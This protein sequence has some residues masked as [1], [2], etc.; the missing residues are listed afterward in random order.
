MRAKFTICCCSTRRRFAARAGQTDE[1][2]PEAAQD[3]AV[4]APAAPRQ[5]WLRSARPFGVE[6]PAPPGERGEPTS[7][8][9]LLSVYGRKNDSWTNRLLPTVGVRRH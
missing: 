6:D 8:N 2:K 9:R 1:E 7:L 5:L 3:G 4:M